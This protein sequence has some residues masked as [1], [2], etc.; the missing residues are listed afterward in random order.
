MLSTFERAFHRVEV[1]GPS[2]SLYPWRNFFWKELVLN[3]GHL[4]LGATALTTKPWL[5]GHFLSFLKGFNYV[6]EIIVEIFGEPSLSTVGCS[7]SFANLGEMSVQ[8]CSLNE[9]KF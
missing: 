2:T 6:Y 9:L 5:A 1:F 4:N 3:P 8:L 7:R